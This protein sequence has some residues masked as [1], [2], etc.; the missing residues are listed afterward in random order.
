MA[1]LNPEMN[2]LGLEIRKP[3]VEEVG[4]QPLSF[5]SA[6]LLSGA[7]A[8]AASLTTGGFVLILI[9]LFAALQA[10]K[11]LEKMPARNVHFIS[12]NAN[13][14]LDRICLDVQQHTSISMCELP[15]VSRV[16]EGCIT[17][18]SRP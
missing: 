5:R 11:K 3:C 17:H 6:S 13:V 2:F 16:Y 18:L 7:A 4:V 9:K 15:R 10:F 14:D 1:H 12:C 8:M